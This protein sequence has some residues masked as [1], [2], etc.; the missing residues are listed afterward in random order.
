MVCYRCFVSEASHC[1]EVER[2]CDVSCQTIALNDDTHA[3]YFLVHVYIILL[4][5]HID[6]ESNKGL[7]HFKYIQC[8]LI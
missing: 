4:G 7:K 8:E 3:V 1:S 2:S 5:V 6:C